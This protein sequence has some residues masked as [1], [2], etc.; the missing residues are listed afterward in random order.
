MSVSRTYILRLNT[1]LS[2]KCNPNIRIGYL[3]LLAVA[4]HI[5]VYETN[6]N[7]ISSICVVVCAVILEHTNLL[8]FHSHHH[9]LHQNNNQNQQH[10]GTV[11]AYQRKKDA[12]SFS[13]I[14]SHSPLSHSLASID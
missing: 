12:A 11:E 6:H 13:M 10:S 7:L 8:Q 4:V 9:H 2:C 1:Q 14:P 3:I 5:K